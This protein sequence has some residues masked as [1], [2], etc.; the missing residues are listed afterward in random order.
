M[1]TVGKIV[2]WP[3]LQINPRRTAQLRTLAG[4]LRPATG[5]SAAR[6]KPRGGYLPS[7]GG[8]AT[9]Q[10][11]AAPGEFLSG[12]LSGSGTGFQGD[13]LLRILRDAVHVNHPVQVRAVRAAGSAGEADH[14][15]FLYA[16]PELDI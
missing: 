13:P 1:K 10:A 12:F 3:T 8:P 15:T 6:L 16:S 2:V 4:G 14:V 9:C 7:L 5:E 11:A